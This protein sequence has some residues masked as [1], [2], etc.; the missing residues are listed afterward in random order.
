MLPMKLSTLVICSRTSE[1]MTASYFSRCSN[2][3]HSSS[4]VTALTRDPCQG[5]RTFRVEQTMLILKILFQRRVGVIFRRGDI[6]RHRIDAQDGCSETSQR[7][8]N[9]SESVFV[10]HE[11]RTYL[12][13]N[14]SST[15]DIH[16][17]QAFQRLDRIARFRERL[18]NLLTNEGDTQL[19][20]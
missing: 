13:K 12:S 1:A 14:S 9:E 4:S 8:E 3:S 19:I 2:C 16:Q 7:L 15:A 11:R 17:L 18:K 20:Q 6:F 5:E 10:D